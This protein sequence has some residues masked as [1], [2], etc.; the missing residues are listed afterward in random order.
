MEYDPIGSTLYAACD[1]GTMLC[2][3]HNKENQTEERRIDIAARLTS[4]SWFPSQGATGYADCFAA[5]CSDGTLRFIQK[6][7]TTEKTIQAHE[8]AAICVK[9]SQDGTSLASAGEDGEV[10]LW[11]RTGNL[12]SNLASFRRP[13]H[14]LS[15][16]GNISSVVVANGNQLCILR[17][18]TKGERIQWEAQP[19]EKGEVLAV[20]WN[21]QTNKILCGGE[22]H[23]YRIFDPSGL[24]LYASAPYDDVV[25]CLAW[26][27]DGTLFVASSQNKIELCDQKGRSCDLQLLPVGSIAN[28]TWNPRGTRLTGSSIDGVIFSAAIVERVI[29]WKSYTARLRNLNRIEITDCSASDTG[30]VDDVEHSR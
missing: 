11:S 8:G 30:R 15:W 20:D 12:R 17:T 9:W 3:G 22:D 5:S 19:K 7:G 27:P 21:G 10:K 1:D 23:C 16:G 13:V 29:E 26:C 14:S 2:F 4:I 28:M 25:S 24:L 18:Q 6:S